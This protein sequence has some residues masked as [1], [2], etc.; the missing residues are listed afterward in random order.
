M[1]RD[2][3]LFLS[4]GYVQRLSEANLNW[5]HCDRDCDIGRGVEQESRWVRL[6]IETLK[7]T[8]P[9]EVAA[10]ESDALHVLPLSRGQLCTSP[11]RTTGGV[12]GLDLS[13]VPLVDKGYP[14]CGAE[15][16]SEPVPL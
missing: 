3:E 16:L 1:I 14:L 2:S 6:G 9:S 5:V 11:Y 7:S 13:G 12:R 10:T 8:I 4:F 15:G